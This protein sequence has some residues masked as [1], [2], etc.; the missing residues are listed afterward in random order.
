MLAR[1]ERRSRGR[2]REGKRGGGSAHLA[3]GCLELSEHALVQW[4]GCVRGSLWLG[5]LCEFLSSF[6]SGSNL[7]AIEPWPSR[8]LTNLNLLGTSVSLHTLFII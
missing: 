5:G 4:S 8:H 7:A 3:C 6:R 1:R 2:R